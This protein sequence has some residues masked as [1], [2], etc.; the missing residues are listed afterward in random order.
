MTGS[1]VLYFALSDHGPGYPKRTTLKGR[2]AFYA[3]LRSIADST[4]GVH[5]ADVGPSLAAKARELHKH[6]GIHTV[7][8]DN[9]QESSSATS[10]ALP[11]AS[12]VRRVR[13]ALRRV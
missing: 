9:G 6:H 3:V 8:G 1:R 11:S 10:E 13:R 12:A 2:R 5:Y 4:K 7:Y